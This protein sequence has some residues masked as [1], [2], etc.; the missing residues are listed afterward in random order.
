MKSDIVGQIEKIHEGINNLKS[1]TD[2]NVLR[3]KDRLWEI[4]HVVNDYRKRKNIDS[5]NHMLS[6][7]METNVASPEGSNTY[8]ESIWNANIEASGKQTTLEELFWKL[9]ELVEK[10]KKS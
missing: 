6:V 3:L 10:P 4:E 2:F 8:D 5:V 9:K 1:R 7:F